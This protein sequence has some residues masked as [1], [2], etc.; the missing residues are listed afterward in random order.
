M[1]KFKDF[2]LGELFDIEKI[3]GF[4][5]NELIPNPYGKYDY[6]TRTSLNN[7]VESITDAVPNRSLNAPNTFSLGLLQMTFFYRERPWYA[8]QF[9][10]KI[11]PKFKANRLIML[12]MLTWLRSYTPRLLSVL[13]RDVDDT[14]V[15]LTI[16]LPVISESDG[17]DWKYIEDQVKALEQDQVKKFDDYLTV[18]GLNNYQLTEE[19]KK[20]L[21]YSP[22]FKKVK[23][24]KTY[25]KRGKLVSVSENGLFTIIPTKKK[26]NAN[27]VKLNGKYPYVARGEGKNGIR[28]YINYD[29]QYLNP[30]NTISF[31]QDTATMYYQPDAY[32]TGDKI[33]I[34][35]LNKNYGKLTE[36]IA[37]YL[38][39]SIRKSFADF[40]WGSSSFALEVLANVDVKLPV[41]SNND[42][43]FDYMEKYIKVIQKLLIKDVVKYKG[44]VMLKTKL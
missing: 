8:G 2:R 39:G 31:G 14:F 44:K 30:A 1:T 35:K 20:I 26:I 5:K 13:V 11:V 40:K 18:I 34:F 42:I 9:V 6:V 16:K 17:I 24:G 32:F 25:K 22:H 23:L 7:G 10:R 29:V 33:Q 28:G 21:Q 27:R 38:I 12:Y 36:N 37:M 4:N 19:D 41:T 15:D 43:D 3:R